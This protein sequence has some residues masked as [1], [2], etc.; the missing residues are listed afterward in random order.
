MIKSLFFNF[1]PAGSVSHNPWFFNNLWSRYSLL[2]RKR[3]LNLSS[4][5]I[6]SLFLIKLTSC[7]TLTSFFALLI[8]FIA[9]VY[10][11][12]LLVLVLDS[13]LSVIL[14]SSTSAKSLQWVKNSEF[15]FGSSWT[16]EKQVS[17]EFQNYW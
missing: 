2:R 10:T 6:C 3:T 16:L 8:C 4:H 12:V 1:R 9:P 7:R 13:Q 11:V 17:V 14:T 5:S 15:A